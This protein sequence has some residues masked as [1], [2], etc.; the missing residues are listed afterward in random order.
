MNQ[1]VR[2]VL[3]GELEGR[4][5]HLDKY[6]LH[7]GNFISETGLHA[8]L[9]VPGEVESCCSI[10]CTRDAHCLRWDRDDF[11]DL[12][13]RENSLRRAVQATLS[14]DI[15]RKLKAQR[16]LLAS[17]VVDAPELWTSKRNEQNDHLYVAILR[18]ILEHPSYLKKRRKELNQYRMIHGIDDNVH[19]KALESL[20]WT[21]KEFEAGVKE[22][23]NNLEEAPGEKRGLMWVSA[24]FEPL[25][26]QT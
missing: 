5:D 3:D 24:I 21:L 23:L 11:V 18:N 7:E 17:G 10:V 9:L 1:H 16:K 13:S 12:L 26:E 2:L 8:G 14:W 22:D 15:V 25:V 20:G 6:K 19:Q 4:R